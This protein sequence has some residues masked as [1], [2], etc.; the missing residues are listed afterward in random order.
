MIKK[1]HSVLVLLGILA[2]VNTAS[3]QTKTTGKKT[4]ASKPVKA[5]FTKDPVTGVEYHFFKHDKKGKLAAMGEFASVT[6]IY[7]TEGDSIIFDSHKKGGDSL[8]AVTIPIKKSFNGCLE[9]GITMMAIGDSAEFK[10]NIDS[11]FTKTFHTRAKPP[12]MAS[13]KNLVFQVRLLKVQTEK[14]IT[15]QQQKALDD[16]KN[17]EKNSIAKYF[18]DSNIHVTPTADSLFILKQVSTNNDPI[19]SGDSVFITYVGKLLNGTLFDQSADHAGAGGFVT[20]NGRPTLAM[21]YSPSMPLIKGWV[22]A[23][24][25]MHL[26]DKVTIL[27]PSTLGYGGRAMGPKIPPYSPLLFDMEM[28]KVVHNTPAGK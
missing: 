20:V 18:S 22:E 10:V 15:D 23:I 12:K 28:L 14:E 6:L 4:T 9:Q 19:Q 2:I 1:M 11:L 17:K 26:G 27:V 7:E 3:A 13:Y 5:T 25:R 24:G 8:G 16:I 21:V